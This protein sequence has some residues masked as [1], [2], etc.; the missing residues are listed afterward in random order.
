[1]VYKNHEHNSSTHGYYSTNW[2]HGYDRRVLS[3]VFVI[4]N[5]V[6]HNNNNHIQNRQPNGCN[7]NFY[8]HALRRSYYTMR[9]K[10][11]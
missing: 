4:Y 3:D 7:D 1:M 10:N 8:R 5:T 2:Q 11:K 6:C 9:R